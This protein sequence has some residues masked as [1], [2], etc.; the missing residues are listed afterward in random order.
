MPNIIK[1][2]LLIEDIKQIIQ[3]SKKM[4]VR[5][6]NTIMVQ[7]YWNIG[8]RIVEEEQNGNIRA[9]YGS[10]L[11]KEISK[12]LT[13]QFGKGFSR[14]NL[15]SMRLFYLSYQKCQTLSGKLS[16]SHYLVLLGVSDLNARSFYEHECENSNWS[17]RELER[18]IDSQ[19]YTRLLLSKGEINKQ[20]VLELANNGVTYQTPDSFIKDPMVLEFVGV[21]EKP[22]LESDL[23]KAII[24]HIE[25]FLLELGRGFMFVGSQQRISIAGMN[26]YVDMV[27][28]NKILKSY[29]LIDL[30]MNKLKP[31]NFG[32][33]NMYV[34]YYK[35]EI[36]DDGD[37]DPIGIILCADKEVSLAKMAIKGIENNIYA[38][39]Y[40]TVMP[41]YETLQNEVHRAIAMFK[42][43]EGK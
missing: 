22:F 23:E 19:L 35:E 7:T 24:D 20:T 41:D 43:K 32:Q 1:T 16:W 5:N 27:F 40:T 18:Q 33:M 21:P 26:Y 17:V 37:S 13:R 3:E 31:E 36:N 4:V 10:S 2:T 42:E 34:N 6:V 30:K 11:L 25:D 8:K 9:D 39:K 12:E 29:V 28:Y 15:Q 14:S 38:A